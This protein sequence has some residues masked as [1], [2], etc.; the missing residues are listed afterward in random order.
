MKR[1]IGHLFCGVWLILLSSGCSS[2]IGSVTKGFATN[3][4]NAILDNPDLEMVRAG[5]PSYLILIDSLVAGSP[6]NSY[7]LEQSAYL[8]SVYAVAFVD[9][10]ARSKLLHTK[11]KRQALLAACKG[12]RNA[13]ELDRR[14]FREFQTWTEGM[15]VKEVPSIFTIATSWLGWIQAH[16]DDF[17]A[18]ADLARVK[19][20]MQKIVELDPDH[21]NGSAYLYLGVFE[22]LLPPAMGGKPELGRDYFETSIELS[23]G[24]NLL[25][26][27]MFADQYA[28]LVFDRELHDELLNEVMAAP[29]EAPGLTL[30]NTVAKQQAATLLASADDYF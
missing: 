27:V 21:D 19:L 23:Q 4:S 5:A 1:S 28:R 26:K 18:I 17:S 29:L 12:L 25:A 10:E 13:C 6:D 24:Q 22:T 16:S 7:L 30:M 3:L 9:D 2:L 14:P 11:A 20:M 8:H 15:K